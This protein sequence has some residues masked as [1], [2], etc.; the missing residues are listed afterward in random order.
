MDT[1][2]SSAKHEVAIGLDITP[3]TEADPPCVSCVGGKLARHTFPD[4]G[5]D[6]EEALAVVYIG[7]CGPFWVAAKD[8]SLYFLLLKDRH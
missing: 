7:L 8:G 4:K 2:M 6:A 3:S 5:S 1:I